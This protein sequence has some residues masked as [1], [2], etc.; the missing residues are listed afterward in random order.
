MLG[1]SLVGELGSWFVREGQAVEALSIDHA[2]PV[3]LTTRGF[4]GVGWQGEMLGFVVKQQYGFSN[5]KAFT[6]KAG[7]F[8]DMA[9]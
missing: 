8:D 3:V 1:S 6:K 7:W 4:S 5:E 9:S 2:P